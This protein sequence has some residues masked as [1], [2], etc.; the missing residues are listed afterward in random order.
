MKGIFG[1]LS[2]VAALAIIAWLAM[3]GMKDFTG[4]KGKNIMGA[5]QRTERVAVKANLTILNSFVNQYRSMHPGE[6]VTMDALK[7]AG[8]ELPECPPGGRFELENGRIV[9]RG[10]E[11]R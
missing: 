9:Y 4:D 8:L 5:K 11:G 7:A 1:L 3:N 6:P 2:L 10:P